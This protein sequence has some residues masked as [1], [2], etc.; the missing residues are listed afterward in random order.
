MDEITLGRQDG[1]LTILVG[2]ESFE[3]VDAVRIDTN[4][5]TTYLD[6][7]ENVSVAAEVDA[8]H[9]GDNGGSVA[10][11]NDEPIGASSAPVRFR[12]SV[13]SVR[14]RRA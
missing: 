5:G 3:L 1:A 10:V 7:I 9:D 8:G 2:E 12:T 4:D 6:N 13:A 14:P 11:G